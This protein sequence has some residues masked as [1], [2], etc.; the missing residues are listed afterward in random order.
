MHNSKPRDYNWYCSQFKAI[1]QDL[2]VQRIINAFAVDVYETHAKIALEEDDI[3]EYN[4]SQ[5]QLKELYDLI[6]RKLGKENA[7]GNKSGKNKKRGGNKKDDELDGALKNRNEFIAYRIIYYV[8]L[9]GNRKY[10]GGSSDIFKVRPC[11]LLSSFLGRKNSQL[12]F[13][14]SPYVK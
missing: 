5:T 9:S 7:T 13:F 10:E 2:T 1:R 4:Q 12:T 8:F 3:N 11:C 14:V 6:E